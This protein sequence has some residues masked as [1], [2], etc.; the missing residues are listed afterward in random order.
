VPI[1]RV[2]TGYAILCDSLRTAITTNPNYDP[3]KGHHG[4]YVNLLFVDGSVDKNRIVMSETHYYWSYI[5]KDG[6]KR[7]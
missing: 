1:T 3:G 2:H 5:W 4:E 6:L 7:Q